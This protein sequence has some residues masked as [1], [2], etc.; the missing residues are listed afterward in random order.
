MNF[1]KSLTVTC[2][3]LMLFGIMAAFSSTVYGEDKASLVSSASSNSSANASTN[4]SANASAD[5]VA[6]AYA[7]ENTDYDS[8]STREYLTPKITYYKSVFDYL[9]GKVDKYLYINSGEAPKDYL[10]TNDNMVFNQWIYLYKGDSTICYYNLNKPSYTCDTAFIACWYDASR[11]ASANG[12][13]KRS[14][15]INSDYYASKDAYL[16]EYV[17]LGTSLTEPTLPEIFGLKQ[18]GFN[19]TA[20]SIE[21]LTINNQDYTMF[22]I[23][24]V[25]KWVANYPSQDT[26]TNLYKYENLRDK[27][28]FTFVNKK[29]K[30]KAIK[31]KVK[32]NCPNYVASE[33]ELQYYIKGKKKKTTITGKVSNRTININLKKLKRKK[34]YK[35]KIRVKASY[36]GNEYVSKWSKLVTVKTK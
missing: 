11:D 19:I 20:P 31:L 22:D 9:N 27:T 3:L 32:Y 14:W 25:G 6:Y 29:G 24:C 36:K 18:N 15:Y 2:C 21:G 34:A 10:P 30:K 12:K 8:S 17:D 4:A 23:D 1:I 5:N 26:D 16:V 28:K 7:H 35:I 13:V 33:Y